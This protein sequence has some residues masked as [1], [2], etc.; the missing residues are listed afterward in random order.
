[1]QFPTRVQ[2]VHKLQVR[3]TT[4]KECSSTKQTTKKRRGRAAIG[5]MGESTNFIASPPA[6]DQPEYFGFWPGE[7]FLLR[8]FEKYAE[9]FKDQ[10]FRISER[11][12]TDPENKWEP[13]IENIEGE[14]WR[15]VEQA[16]E[17]IEVH[18]HFLYVAGEP[19]KMCCQS[20]TSCGRLKVLA[21]A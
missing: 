12:R 5:R 18:H 14:Y 11:R 7:P 10:Y 19:C 4:A 20:A 9:D 3:Q 6:N 2:Q 16:T 8:A 21:W 17:Q 1:M 15:I 13:T